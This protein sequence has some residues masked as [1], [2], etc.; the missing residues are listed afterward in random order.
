[1]TR[2]APLCR[3]IQACTRCPLYKD[4]TQGVCGEGPAR[5]TLMLVGEQPGDREDRAGRPFVGPAGRL[6][7]QALAEAGI[8]RRQVYVTNAVKHYKHTTVGKR[9]LHKRPNAHEIQ[10]CRWWLELELAAVQPAL[11]VALGATAVQSLF[12]KALPIGPRRGRIETTALGVRVL[13]TIHPSYL[14]RIRDEAD[15]RAQYRALVADLKAA[16]TGCAAGAARVAAGSSAVAR[17][18]RLPT[19]AAGGRP[20]SRQSVSAAAKRRPRAGAAGR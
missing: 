16:V 13:T 2:L 12:G 3:D 6:L 8:D 5:A 7:D 10:Q 11:V 20:T 4:A 15:R 17:P 14:L 9:R 1:M 19:R 18:R